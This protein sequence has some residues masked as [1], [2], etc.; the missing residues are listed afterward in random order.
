MSQTNEVVGPQNV[1]GRVSV[2]D[3]LPRE[4]SQSH[5]P[6]WVNH[7]LTKPN[8]LQLSWGGIATQTIGLGNSQY[9]VRGMYLEYENTSD[10][11]DVPS[12]DRDEGIE[13]YQDLAF[14][15]TRDFLRIPLLFSPAVSIEPGYEHL[16]EEGINGNRLT[17]FSQSQG[18]RGFHNKA[19]SYT[20][21][22][23]LFGVALVATP[24]FSDPA[25]DIIFSRT[26]FEQA[27]H[28]AKS[29]TGQFG[30]TWEIIFK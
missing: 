6:S 29:N 17:F 28:A 20:A 23:T 30:V 15:G 8:Q 1:A 5:L 11:I 18:N 14:S 9:R 22:S 21:Q 12:Y 10:P 19:F 4:P 24:D 26:Y 3:V 7:R 27:D 25:K 2:W 13:Y 16:Y